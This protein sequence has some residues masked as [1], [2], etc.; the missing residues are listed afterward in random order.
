MGSAESNS[1]IEALVFGASGITGWA[2]T[3]SALSYPTP[4][5]FSRV[6]GFTSR[7]LSLKDL[8]FPSDPRLQLYSG[9][10][11]SQ[12]ADTITKY[13]KKIE[14][15]DQITHHTYIEAGPMKVQSRESKRTL[16]L[17]STPSQQSRMFIQIDNSGRFQQWYGFE[18]GTNVYRETPLKENAPRVPSPYGDHPFFYPQIDTLT[19]LAEGKSWKFADIRPNAIVGFVPSHN[20]MNIAEPLALYL[21]LLKSVNPTLSV[22][23][24]GTKESYTHLQSNCSSDQLGRFHVYDSLHPELTAGKAFNIADEDRGVLGLWMEKERGA[25]GWVRGQKDLWDSWTK[26]NGL[27]PK[28]EWTENGGEIINFARGPYSTFDRHYDLGEA[29]RIGFAESVDHLKGYYVAFDRM[30]AAKIIP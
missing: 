29:R 21:S 27:R 8:D 14:N 11:L 4:T 10:D 15:I 12:D 24:P 18:F 26:E 1:A 30:R 13:L 19:R 9:L 28:V 23:F 5:A 20:P 6:V 2:I 17:S 22:P 25:W 16:I 3:N 7:P